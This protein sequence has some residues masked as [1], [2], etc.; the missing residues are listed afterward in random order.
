MNFKAK[1]EGLH[2]NEIKIM[3]IDFGFDGYGIFVPYI[4]QFPRKNFL[5]PQIKAVV[6]LKRDL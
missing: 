4:V 1:N 6:I 5:L 3:Y 2:N